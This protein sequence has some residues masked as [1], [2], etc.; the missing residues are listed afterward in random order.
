[1]NKLYIDTRD[2]NRIV[3]RLEAN[4]KIF[5]EESKASE[6]R[7]Q[8]TLPLI[9]KALARARIA[10]SSIDEINVEEQAG[11]FTGI[12]VGVAIANALAFSLNARINGKELGEL[13]DPAYSV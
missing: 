5:E 6:L 8:M 13:A 2:N 7:A 10:P 3:V 12:R 1:M 4:G 11:S 9:E